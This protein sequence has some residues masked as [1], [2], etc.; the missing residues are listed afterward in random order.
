MRYRVEGRKVLKFRRWEP[1]DVSFKIAARRDIHSYQI[2]LNSMLLLYDDIQELSWT[3]RWGNLSSWNITFSPEKLWPFRKR[4]RRYARYNSSDM[5]TFS[6]R[7]TVNILF[8]ISHLLIYRMQR[9]LYNPVLES[10]VKSSQSSSEMITQLIRNSLRGSLTLDL[11]HIISRIRSS[12]VRSRARTHIKF[13]LTHIKLF[14][15][16]STWS[17]V[18]NRW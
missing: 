3:R 11:F 16:R 5:T 9:R 12:S 4:I 10:D 2:Y 18:R 14:S 1:A 7:I 6:N 17:F 13:S 15:I 8:N